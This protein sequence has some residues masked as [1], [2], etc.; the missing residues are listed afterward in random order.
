MH[1]VTQKL[2]GVRLK[3]LYI[4]V[5][6]HFHLSLPHLCLCVVTTVGELDTI[7]KNS[8]MLSCLAVVLLSF[9]LGHRWGAHCTS[10]TW[11]CLKTLTL[12]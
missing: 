10:S 9:L 6:M 8:L 2:P 1:T 5:Y 12:R 3:E 4:D 7:F 11:N